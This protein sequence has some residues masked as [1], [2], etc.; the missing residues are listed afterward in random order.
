[1]KQPIRNIDDEGARA[2]GAFDFADDVDVVNPLAPG[3]IKIAGDPLFNATD[4]RPVPK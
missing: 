3:N 1:M 4:N 2:N